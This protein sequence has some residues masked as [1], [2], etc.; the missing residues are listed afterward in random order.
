MKLH[1]KKAAA[2]AVIVLC[3]VIGLTT[4]LAPE[5]KSVPVPP[6]IVPAEA[7]DKNQI[8]KAKDVPSTEELPL[9]TEKDIV[10]IEF[11]LFEPLPYVA[12]KSVKRRK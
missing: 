7:P 6:Q 3:W 1:H 8:E 12:K 9:P 4:L 5:A 2:L 11:A 10:G